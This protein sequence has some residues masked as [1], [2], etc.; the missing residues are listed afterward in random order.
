M[1]SIK[2]LTLA[3]AA[4]VLVSCGASEPK[5]YVGTIVDAT[6]NNVIVK[7]LTGDQTVVFSTE[8]ADMSAANGMLIGN[9][10]TVD[11]T[12]DLTEGTPATKVVTDATYA[13]AVGEW[14]M[15][16]P[17]NADS[18]MGF[19]LMVEGEAESINMATLRYSGWELQ[20]EENK[21]ILKGV[22][23]GSG[24]PIDFTETAVLSTNA[25]GQELLTIEGTEVV[26]TKHPL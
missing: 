15:P 9:L 4:F 20:G 16:D 12:G 21:I 14:T 8:N 26:L 22:S 13:K 17:I 25:E 6:M 18:V 3:I 10:I 5:Q 7:E 2:I 19:K 1:K 24:A 23:E 11:Y